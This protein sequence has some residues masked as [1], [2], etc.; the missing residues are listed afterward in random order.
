M[1]A[2]AAISLCGSGKESGVKSKLNQ[3]HEQNPKDITIVA[4][5]LGLGDATVTKSMLTK[6]TICY[7]FP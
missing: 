2:D 7:P 3:L 5:L 1:L 6:R 4:G